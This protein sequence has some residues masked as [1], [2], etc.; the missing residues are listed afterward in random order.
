[1]RRA[2]PSTSNKSLAGLNAIVTLIHY[3]GAVRSAPAFACRK[4]SDKGACDDLRESGL[5]AE[6]YSRKIADIELSSLYR[7]NGK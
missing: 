7:F 5:S 4:G 2:C 1:W 3:A 6:F